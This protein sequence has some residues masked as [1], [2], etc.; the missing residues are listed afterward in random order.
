MAYSRFVLCKT[1][2]K[3]HKCP[4]YLQAGKEGRSEEFQA[5]QP[6]LNPWVGGGDSNPGKQFQTHKGHEGDQESSAH[7]Y[8]SEI[9]LNQP[10]NLLKRSDW[11]GG[12]G[13]SSGYCSS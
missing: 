5:S 8:K 4:S 13:E 12:Q 11:V 1:T 7:L 3:C 2:V 10:G 9:M 6:H